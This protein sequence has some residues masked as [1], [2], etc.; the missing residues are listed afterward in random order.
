MTC[1]IITDIR[2]R[3]P[4]RE[5]FFSLARRVFG[6]SFEAWYAAGWWTQRYIPYSAVVD[7][8]VAA[9]VSVNVI[10]MLWRGEE[11]RCVQLGTVMTDPDFRGRGLSRRLLET[12]LP[13]WRERCDMLCLFANDTVLD[14]YPRFG[15]A[16]AWEHQF[17]CTAERGGGAARKL[18]MHSAADT[19]LFLKCSERSNPYSA[20]AMVDN[21]GLLMF[22]CA[23]AL[24]DCVYYSEVLDAAAVIVRGVQGDLCCDLFCEEKV[25]LRQAL[26]AFL[27]GR[28]VTLGFTPKEACGEASV[29]MDDDEALFVLRGKENLFSG[30]S[31]MLPLLSH[32]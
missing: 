15:F 29:R 26:G 18:D 20:L 8:R 3:A 12:V 19:A 10:D 16:R 9:N 31:V 7:G 6:L 4:L 30:R 17:T 11:R 21:P 1:E 25:P 27:P 22:Y 24:S 5:S 28:R 32:A 2:D 13:Q 14:F 23:G